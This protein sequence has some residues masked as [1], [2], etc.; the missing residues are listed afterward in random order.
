MA[1]KPF[2]LRAQMLRGAC[3][4]PYGLDLAGILASRLWRSGTHGAHVDSMIER[5]NDLNIPLDMCSAGD[6]WHWMATCAIAQVDSLHPQEP[7]TFYRVVNDSWVARAADR[8]LPYYHPRSSAY[9]DVMMPAPITLTPTL[10][11]YGV[12]DLDRILKMVSPIRSLGKRRAKGEGRVLSW[13]ITE[14]IGVDTWVHGHIGQESRIVRPIPIECANRLDVQ[15]QLAWHAIRPPSWNP[16]R[17]RELA[18]DKEEEVF[19]PEEWE[20]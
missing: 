12:G 15:Y 14:E 6:D 19:L 8:P 3:F 11:W 16:N 10:D 5:P 13:T 2:H 7:R 4:E 18:V 20:L 1:M 17:L 9:R